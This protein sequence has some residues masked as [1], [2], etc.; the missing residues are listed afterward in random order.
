MYICAVYLTRSSQKGSI[1][2]MEVRTG[3]LGRSMEKLSK[4]PGMKLGNLKPK[5]QSNLIR[6]VKDNKKGFHKYTGDKRQ[7]RE[8]AYLPLNNGGRPI[9]QD[10]KKAEELKAFA[11]VSTTKTCLK[12]QGFQKAKGKNCSMLKGSRSRQGTLKQAKCILPLALTECTQVLNELP[13]VTVKPA[14]LNNP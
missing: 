13:D 12:E 1:R 5:V 11:S 10:I 4:H 3:N 7:A 6:N 9:T 8:N 14:T 2:R